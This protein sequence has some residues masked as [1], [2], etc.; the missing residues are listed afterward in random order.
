MRS[1]SGRHRAARCAE[2]DR[3]ARKRVATAR[4]GSSCCD[5]GRVERRGGGEVKSR[6]ARDLVQSGPRHVR[7]RAFVVIFR[8]MGAGCD[9]V[10]PGGGI[11]RARRIGANA[12]FGAARS[13]FCTKSRVCADSSSSAA[14][15]PTAQVLKLLEPKRGTLPNAL[16]YALFESRAP[17]AT[18][19]RSAPRGRTPRTPPSCRP[20]SH[21][22]A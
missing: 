12:G 19:R 4:G 21:G 7:D 9:S 6:Q 3:E 10:F 11:R 5:Q 13:P 22:C 17:G 18:G 1:A 16:L 8:G 15:L 14:Q 2:A 20:S